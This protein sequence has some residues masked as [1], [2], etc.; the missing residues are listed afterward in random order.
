MLVTCD[1]KVAERLLVPVLDPGAAD[2]LGADETGA[3]AAPLAAK[4]LHADARHRRQHEARRDLH[5]ADVPAL[6]QVDIHGFG[7]VLPGIDRIGAGRYHS[8]PRRRV[9]AGFCLEE[10]C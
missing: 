3:E 5:I 10:A 6:A 7:M 4:R 9:T 8:R 2:H 1:A